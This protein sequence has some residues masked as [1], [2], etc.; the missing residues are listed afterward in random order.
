MILK[1][2]NA[3]GKI[4]GINVYENNFDGEIEIMD[5]FKVENIEESTDDVFGTNDKMLTLFLDNVNVDTIVNL[6]EIAENVV[7]ENRGCGEV[8][9]EGLDISIKKFTE[10]LRQDILEFALDYME[11]RCLELRSRRL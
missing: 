8:D 6:E 7:D 2:V 1:I 4:Y 5:T 10:N 11:E 9:G 3:D